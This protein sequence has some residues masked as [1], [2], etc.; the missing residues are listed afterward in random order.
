MAEFGIVLA[1]GFATRLRPLSYTKP[2]PL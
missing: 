2:K 1:G